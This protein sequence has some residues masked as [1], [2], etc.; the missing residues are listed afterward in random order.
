MNEIHP[1]IQWNTYR[2][3]RNNIHTVEVEPDQMRYQSNPE[4]IGTTETLGL[5]HVEQQNPKSLPILCIWCAIYFNSQI[6]A[7]HSTHWYWETGSG[8]GTLCLMEGGGPPV[9][10]WTGSA[11]EKLSDASCPSEKVKVWYIL[12]GK[13]LLHRIYSE[14]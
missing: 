10:L 7:L 11:E 12:I 8:T 3:E 6:R 14:D 2:K 4:P 5:V 13:G 1:S 9:A